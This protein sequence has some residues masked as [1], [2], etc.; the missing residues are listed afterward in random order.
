MKLSTLMF[1]GLITI[2]SSAAFAEGGAEHLK[3][4]YDNLHFT[5]KQTRGIDEQTASRNSRRVKSESVEDANTTQQPN[6]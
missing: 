3:A 2:A 6:S 4:Y 5:Q 1:A